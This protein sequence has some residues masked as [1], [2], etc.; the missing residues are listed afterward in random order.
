MKRIY[1]NNC[2]AVTATTKIVFTAE[3]GNVP[4]CTM[5]FEDQGRA[6]D[7]LNRTKREVG[8]P[9]FY[10][11]FVKDINFNTGCMSDKWVRVESGTRDI[12]LWSV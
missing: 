2:S 5:Y 12:V 4:P 6:C 8:Y 3:N 1:D 7:Q 11:L 9:F 10:D